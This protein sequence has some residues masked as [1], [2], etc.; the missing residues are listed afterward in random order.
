MD[1]SRRMLRRVM[2]DETGWDPFEEMDRQVNALRRDFESM[3]RWLEKD[4][5][6]LLETSRS[7][8]KNVRDGDG[9][10]GY[11]RESRNEEVDGHG[12]YRKTY[13]MQSITVYG[14]G[15]PMV[16]RP[17]ASTSV[18]SATILLAV[19]VAGAYGAGMHVVNKLYPKTA[20]DARKRPLLLIQWPFLFLFSD[21]F[22]D[23]L[24]RA[25]EL[26]ASEPKK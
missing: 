14:G 13:S 25:K 15:M 23:E 2:L 18:P 7:T 3:D 16:S 20:L 6:D 1:R 19:L 24:K 8:W 17:V 12:G 4:A 11:K 26:D 5:R 22:R 10:T 21:R 9:W